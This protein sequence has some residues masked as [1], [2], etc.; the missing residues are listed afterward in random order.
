MPA[1]PVAA[2]FQ[3]RAWISGVIL[4]VLFGCSPTQQATQP[5]ESSSNRPAVTS[6]TPATQTL[7]DRLGVPTYPGSVQAGSAES[8]ESAG[9]THYNVLLT[10]SDSVAK[11]LAFYKDQ[12]KF[13]SSTKDGVSQ[14][15]GRTKQGADVL[16]F[17]QPEED[18][19]HIT[20]KGI[21]YSKPPKP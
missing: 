5:T 19:T 14:L 11:V 8:P 13:A 15:V 2:N 9:S 6:Q 16:I 1:L 21:L 4:L 20:V 10:T 3:M 18:G 17:I 12:L 7:L